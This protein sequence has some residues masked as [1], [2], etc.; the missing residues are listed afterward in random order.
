M[1]IETLRGMLLWCAL[2]NYGALLAWFA[3]FTLGHDWLWRLH[4]R[5]FRL[6][7]AQFDEV[8]YAGMAL[9]KLAILFFNLVPWLALTLLV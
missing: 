8:H 9:Y 4:G 2:I 5:W 7:P 3:L 1:A 6:S